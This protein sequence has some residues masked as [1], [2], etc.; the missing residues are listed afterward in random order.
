MTRGCYPLSARPVIKCFNVH[1]CGRIFST[2]PIHGGFTLF[3]KISPIIEAFLLGVTF[4]AGQGWP[5][6]SIATCADGDI[7]WH[8]RLPIYIY[9]YIFIY[10]YLNIY[11]YIFTYVHIYIYT[12]Y[13]TY[14]KYHIS[15][16]RY[17]I[18]SIIYQIY[19][20][21]HSKQIL[22]YGHAPT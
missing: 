2:R 13:K 8:K 16:I 5:W 7:P 3:P 9:I 6:L 18:S 12:S 15:S 21:I 1:R 14:I 20:Y 17:H 4:L 10:L 11:T 19:I 22:L